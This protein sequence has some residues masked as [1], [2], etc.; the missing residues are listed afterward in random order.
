MKP[1]ALALFAVLIP[2]TAWADLNEKSPQFLACLQV[3][4]NHQ[5]Q[6]ADAIQDCYSHPI[7]RVAAH[8]SYGK[9][10]DVLRANGVEALLA[11][12]ICSGSGDVAYDPEPMFRAIE[13]PDF[14]KCLQVIRLR[15]GFTFDEAPTVC[16][17][18]M[19]VGS[20]PRFES[21]L[22]DNLIPGSKRQDRISILFQCSALTQ[23][24]QKK[25]PDYRTK[26][27]LL[28]LANQLMLDA[29]Q[30]FLA[31]PNWGAADP[32][33]QDQ[34]LTALGLYVY[35]QSLEI[36]PHAQDVEEGR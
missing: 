11:P 4:R 24:E 29:N 36:R 30:K 16:A 15:A 2:A 22:Q 14:P 3:E 7:R 6:Y 34:A 13:N 25:D 5:I 19:D 10:L 27:E 26:Q 23:K 1:L 18:F 20:D 28:V 21:C 8:P 32:R 9:C 31:Q 12:E 35:E 17:Q 33:I